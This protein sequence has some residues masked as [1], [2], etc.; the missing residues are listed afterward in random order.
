[1]TEI[2]RHNLLTMLARLGRNAIVF[3]CFSF[4]ILLP[5]IV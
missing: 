2:L 3:A 4:V 1:M 5:F